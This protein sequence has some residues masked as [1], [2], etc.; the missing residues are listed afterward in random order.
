MFL[1]RGCF[2]CHGRGGVGGAAPALAPLVAQLSDS[3]LREVLEKPTAKMK[4]GGM[5][6]VEV[7]SEELEMLLS[8]LRTLPA[9]RQ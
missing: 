5:P 8:Y 4:E 1:K 3:Q 7:T 9:P 2:T 6:P